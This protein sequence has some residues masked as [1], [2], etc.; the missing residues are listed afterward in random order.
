[1]YRTTLDLLSIG[2]INQSS[3]YIALLYVGER[4]GGV[5]H[6]LSVLG[7]NS[8]TQKRCRSPKAINHAPT[9]VGGAT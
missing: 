5:K 8:N 9:G 6:G 7:N 1:M 2:D 4:G 3:I